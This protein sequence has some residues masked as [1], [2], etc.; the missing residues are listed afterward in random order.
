MD[1]DLHCDMKKVITESERAVRPEETVFRA[2]AAAARIGIT[3]RQELQ[4]F[5]NAIWVSRVEIS[6]KSDIRMGGKGPTRDQCLASGSMEFIERWSLFRKD[7]FKTQKF[8]CLDLLE[9]RRY[10]MKSF[11]ELRNTKCCAAGNNY[12]EAV[13]HCL[14]EL[15]E[16][17]IPFANNWDY[18][19]I[20]DV[21]ELLPELPQWIKDST[22]LVMTPTGFQQ[23]YKFTAIQYPFNREFDTYRPL[24]VQR[25]GEFIEIVPVRKDPKKHSP[26]SGG[27]AG[28]NPRKTAFR[29]INEMF[30]FQNRVEDYTGGKK[31]ILPEWIPT[32][33]AK[34]LENYETDSI[35][36]DIR[37]I[38]DVLGED[39]FIGAVDITDPE[40]QIPVVKLVSDFQPGN[41]LVDEKQMKVFFD[42]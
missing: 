1:F 33:R 13:L 11:L 23:F 26:N 20:V 17:R 8:T 30:Q 25:R 35:T 32:A 12:E 39:V 36:G 34:D 42:F 21:D 40:M 14:H 22:V 2:V 37:L 15:I 19:K 28:L 41:S 16:T 27:A 5:D 18:C 6:E 4:D 10:Y 24:E 9:N 38:L 29:A 3:L 31:R 7:I